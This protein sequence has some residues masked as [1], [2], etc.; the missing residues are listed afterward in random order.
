MNYGEVLSKAWK[1]IWRN[2]V[3]WILGILAGCSGGGGSGGSSNFNR[4]GGGNGNMEEYGR[5]MQQFLERI[6]AWVWLL[7]VVGVLVLILVGLYLSTMGRIGLVLGAVRGDEGQQSQ[8]LGKLWGDSQPFFWRMFLL[9]LLV[10]I[11]G[12]VIAL[13]IFVPSIA[14][15]VLTAG[16]GMLCL[17]PFI[18]ILIPIS[19]LAT[20]FIEQSAVAL[21]TENLGV[22]DALQRGWKVFRANLGALVVL[23]LIIGIGGFLV[24][25][26]L[27][28]PMLITMIPLMVQFMN[29]G[30]FSFNAL[31]IA[32]LVLLALYLPVMLVLGGIL[33]SYVGSVW[34]LAFRRLTALPTSS[35]LP[36]TPE[37]PS[38]AAVY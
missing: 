6:P 16:I 23:G 7:V 5:Q 28:V 9:N 34:T 18:C 17:L 20:I 29:S 22:M 3:L 35:I 8:S 24:G 30:D 1:I 26:V 36:A 2:K 38:G 15:T 10:G 13:I 31:S 32:S 4:S 33:K 14:L 19:W 12:F 25:L 27:A 21:V 37:P 11:I